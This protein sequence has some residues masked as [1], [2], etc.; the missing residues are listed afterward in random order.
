MTKNRFDHCQIKKKFW[1]PSK[2]PGIQK[3][4]KRAVGKC[5]KMH[6]EVVSCP[7]MNSEFCIEFKKV[8]L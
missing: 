7:K 3:N 8:T 4:E 1:K 2:K 5:F 6:S